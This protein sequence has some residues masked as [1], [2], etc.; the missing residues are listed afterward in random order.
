MDVPET[1]LVLDLQLLQNLSAISYTKMRGIFSLIA[2]LPMKLCLFKVVNLDVW[3]RSLNAN[4]VTH[5]P[6]CTRACTH[7]C[8]STHRHICV[9]ILYSHT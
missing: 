9:Y 2:Y 3:I 5:T 8:T 4:L 6:A 1:Q 7:A